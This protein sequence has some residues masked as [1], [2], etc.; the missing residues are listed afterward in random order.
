MGS[1]DTPV[2]AESPYEGA[3][4]RT[5]RESVHI[6]LA[7][8]QVRS[9]SVYV[10]VDVVADPALRQPA[11]D[12]ALHRFEGGET[13]ALPFVFHDPKANKLA[14]VVPEVLRH[15]A[16]AARARLAT[17]I[18]EATAHPVP[19]YAL[20]LTLCVGTAELGAY[21][22]LPPGAGG[23][24]KAR[25][26]LDEL[27]GSLDARSAQL[28]AL[29]QGLDGRD[30]SLGAREAA[31]TGRDRALDDKAGALGAREVRLVARGEA[32]TGQED[33]V[34]LDLERLEVM[35]REITLREQQLEDRQAAF[36]ERQAAF[37]ERRRE[38][39]TE[40]T[41][42]DV[43]LPEAPLPEAP[44]GELAPSST[45]PDLERDEP[46]PPGMQTL[47]SVD[48]LA[49]EG[50]V[51]AVDSV[52]EQEL[53]SVDEAEFEDIGD[54]A[55]EEMADDEIEELDD[56]EL[57]DDDEIEE[58]G[59]DAEFIED[60]E[61]LDDAAELLGDVAELLG[62]DV[63][64]L[65]PAMSL[66]AD[67]DPDDFD[68]QQTAIAPSLDSE[69]PRA[70]E[71]VI[72]A[73]ITPPDSFLDDL[74]VEAAATVRNGEVWIFTRLSE[75]HEEAFRGGADL[76]VQYVAPDDYPVVLLALAET[77]GRRP[78]TRRAAIDPLVDTDV[79]EALVRDF[80]ASIAVFGPEGRFE[81]TFEVTAPRSLNVGLI[82]ERVGRAKEP[83][84]D[85]A[86]AVER[87][88]AAPP[89]VRLGGHPF[90]PKEPAT[91]AVD[92]VAELSQLVKWSAPAKLEMALLALSIPRDVV[93]SAFKRVLTTAVDFGLALPG[94]LVSRAV[95]LGVAV[96][97][98]ELVARQV[99]AFAELSQRGGGGLSADDIAS[100]WQSLLDTA[101]ENE[102]TIDA[103]VHEAAWAAIRRVR[104]ESSAP[105][106]MAIDPAEIPKMAE[107]ELLVLLDHPKVRLA[108]ALELL[109]RGNVELLPVIYKAV[110]KMPREEVL[111]LAPRVVA[112]GEASCDALIDGLTA[113]KTFVRQASALGLGELR[114][115]RAVVPLLHLLQ[116]EPSDVWLEVARVLGSFGTATARA[117][118]RTLKDPKGQEGRF[119]Y[120]LA[121]LAEAGGI[122]QV[123]KLQKSTDKG[124]AAIALE[125]STLR[126]SAKADTEL[127]RGRRQLEG[128]DPIRSFSQRFYEELASADQ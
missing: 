102:V 83:A 66:P 3:P 76:L 112:V 101:A 88:L 120:T 69:P 80:T 92:S 119:S 71:S 128:D 51:E 106:A 103:D 110:R 111:V 11:L 32:V 36:E 43:P 63:R 46:A 37:E 95:S 117:L 125:A 10:A 78:Y 16:L 55:V 70:I 48:E 127:A 5:R 41:R 68:E 122:K 8:G 99:V 60:A 96:E 93:D 45:R 104:G 62:D 116:N 33:D 82:L 18:A 58:L 13:L 12:G 91:S 98:G 113:R 7:D 56:A 47:D 22:A 24:Q 19:A 74:D 4:G 42:D 34:R 64:D 35:E 27:R 39:A 29:R 40:S 52:D 21:L 124:T 15:E 30:S 94:P 9:V 65:A 44:V 53:G 38:A 100:N 115:R 126:E 1:Q 107:L 54:A 50:A 75:G 20:E 14:L 2:G 26:E 123:Q 90:D 31:A 118:T 108:A 57:L 28:E 114:P 105:R 77:E 73:P 17:Q 85:S 72:P 84:V 86:T 25:A 97:P 49:D 6:P 61:L 79:L 81:R 121:H 59:D 109:G 23:S 87:A 67:V 89:P